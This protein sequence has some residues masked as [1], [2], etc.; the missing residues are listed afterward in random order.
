MASIQ[1]IVF[2]YVVNFHLTLAFNLEAFYSTDNSQI[3]R[4]IYICT[5]VHI[6]I[7]VS[8]LYTLFIYSYIFIYTYFGLLRSV[9][10]VMVR[11]V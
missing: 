4:V 6:G 5:Y 8:I 10:T 11:D 7:N 1:V 3:I 9:W 2:N